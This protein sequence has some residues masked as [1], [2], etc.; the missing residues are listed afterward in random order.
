MAIASR[1]EQQCTTLNTHF[2]V[3][4][5]FYPSMSKMY[6]KKII[7]LQEIPKHDFMGVFHLTIVSISSK[8]KKQNKNINT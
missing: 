2:E 1:L 3:Y 8:F 6:R 7:S 5:L 4:H